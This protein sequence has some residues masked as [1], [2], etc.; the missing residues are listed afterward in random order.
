MG[1]REVCLVGLGVA[2]GFGNVTALRADTEARNAKV[3][4]EES[5]RMQGGWVDLGLALIM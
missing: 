1:A 3:F 2:L 4:P 5:R